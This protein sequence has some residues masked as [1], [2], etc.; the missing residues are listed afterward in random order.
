MNEI[1]FNKKQELQQ[2]DKIS[3]G[4]QTG[5]QPFDIAN[6]FNNYF[7]N[8]IEQNVDMNNYRQTHYN[9]DISMPSSMESF[10][11]NESI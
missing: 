1:I 11:T 8:I 5:T 3:Y 6:I 4:N 10:E 9:I 2:I 7:V